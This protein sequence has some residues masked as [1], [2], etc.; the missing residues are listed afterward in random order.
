MNGKQ[1]REN[2]EQAVALVKEGKYLEA[3]L[4]P[5]LSSDLQHVVG[6]VK[7]A[8]GSSANSGALKETT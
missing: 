3:L 1:A 2:Y 7:Q 4:V 6:K 8:M 5:M